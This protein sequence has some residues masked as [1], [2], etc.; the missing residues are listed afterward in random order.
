MLIT[1][2]ER[3][4]P[5]FVTSSGVVYDRHEGRRSRLPCRYYAFETGRG[6]LIGAAGFR[7][8]R[9]LARR[10]KDGEAVPDAAGG[11]HVALSPVSCRCGRFHGPKH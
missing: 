1:V 5:K 11:R 3:R 9:E 8:A 4:L 7:D 2:V 10:L 6:V